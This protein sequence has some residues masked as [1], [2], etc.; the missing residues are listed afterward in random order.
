ME[1]SITLKKEKEEEAF[2][3]EQL[4]KV[5]ILKEKLDEITTDYE[6]KKS[7]VYKMAK[8]YMKTSNADKLV[9]SVISKAA[10]AKK[11][12]VK[13][14]C[15][16]MVKRMEL[17]WFVDKLSEVLTKE[18]KEKVISK[19]YEVTN[20]NGLTET[21]KKYNVPSTE[22]LDFIFVDKTVNE[23]A[24]EQLY[25]FG[26]LNESSIKD[27]YKSTVKTSYLQMRKAKRKE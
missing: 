19:K 27:C 6:T 21:L 2:L 10:P 17:V 24:L 8:E 18:Q 26:E 12:S 4:T 16:S 25:E 15:L 13:S 11:E 7:V 20:W 22:I 1:K 3:I 23:E 9:F 14:F 5:N